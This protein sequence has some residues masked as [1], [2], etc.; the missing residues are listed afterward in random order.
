[1]TKAQGCTTWECSKPAS[2]DSP[3]EVIQHGDVPKTA[4]DFSGVPT[5]LVDRTTVATRGL[6]VP[7]EDQATYYFFY[8]F[9]SEDP[10]SLSAY[11]HMLPTVYREDSSFRALPRVVEAI[12]LASISNRKH[13]PEL[14]VA[15]G[16]NYAR[17]LRAISASIQDS[18]E[19]NT[20]QTLMAVMLL[21]LFEVMH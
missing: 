10:S 9:V 3:V 12:G 13:A 6:S 8:N 4:T 21:G 19:A 17:G 14:M 18:K 5:R 20:D 16:R 11:S 15:A 2:P 7:L 1:M